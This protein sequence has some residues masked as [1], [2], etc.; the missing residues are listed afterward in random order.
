MSDVKSLPTSFVKGDGTVE[1][2]EIVEI[3]PNEILTEYMIHK[4]CKD[5][6]TKKYW[7]G[8]NMN[9]VDYAEMMAYEKFDAYREKMY[10]KKLNP[11]K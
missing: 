4:L 3:D 2:S 5:D 7:I 8:E 6:M 1:G 10:H 11:A 9:Q